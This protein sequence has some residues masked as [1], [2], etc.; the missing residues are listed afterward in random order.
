MFDFRKT[1]TVIEPNYINEIRDAMVD[2]FKYLG[3]TNDSNL[4]WKI[5][6]Q[7]LVAKTNQ[8][9]FFV[10]KL[11]SFYV[12]NNIL[13][14]FYQSVIQSIISLCICVWYGNLKAIDSHRLERVIKAASKTN[15]LDIKGTRCPGSVELVFEKRL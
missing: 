4:N 10:R 11:K 15:G 8:R 14:L 9:M 13:S 1:K 6:T 12:R 7:K 3:T 5:I 2:N